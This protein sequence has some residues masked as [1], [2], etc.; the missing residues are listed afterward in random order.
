MKKTEASAH[1]CKNKLAMQESVGNHSLP[2]NT[3]EKQRNGGR[4]KH[5]RSGRQGTRYGSLWMACRLLRPVPAIELFNQDVRSLICKRRII[6][7]ILRFNNSDHRT[8]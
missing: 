7:V 2:A 5:Q 6:D 1:R 3:W 8:A 4:R